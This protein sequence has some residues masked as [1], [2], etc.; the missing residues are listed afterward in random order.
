MSWR[1]PDIAQGALKGRE[2]RAFEPCARRWAENR[3]VGGKKA[4]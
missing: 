2:G 1:L 3:F 4:I